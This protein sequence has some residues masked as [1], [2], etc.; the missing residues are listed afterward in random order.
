M[1]S[2]GSIRFQHECAIDLELQLSSRA[3][4]VH[5][6]LIYCIVISMTDN[7]LLCILGH[8]GSRSE[9]CESVRI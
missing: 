7:F 5:E 4:K 1:E 8:R 2:N 9:Y 6:P 3:P